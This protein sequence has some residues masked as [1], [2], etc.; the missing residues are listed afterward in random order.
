MKRLRGPQSWLL[1]GYIAVIAFTWL[2]QILDLPYHLMGAR[3]TL[4]NWEESIL[5]TGFILMIGIFS[6][7]VISY[8]EGKW[9]KANAELQK[10]ACTDSLT[11]A[12]IRR[13][14]LARAEKE[15]VRAK[16]FD[17]PFTCGIIDL[18][19]FKSINDNFGHLAGDK[20]LTEFVRI[21]SSNIRQQDFIGRLGG[22]EFGI[23]FV[24]AVDNEA[25]IIVKR[26]H[27]EWDKANLLSDGGI[28]LTISFS[29]GISST[30]PTDNELIDCIRR[31]DK[32]LYNAKQEGK[33][34]TAFV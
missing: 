26:I 28:K 13:E 34:K 27:E 23:V 31:T 32:A 1:V 22:D 16:R 7:R 14:F 19:T 20:V 33:N 8:Y 12:L 6:W 5:E 18:D 25:Q 3:P 10:L 21:A 29:T 2:I 11:G 4:I 17:R 9:S 15:F 30:L 24:E